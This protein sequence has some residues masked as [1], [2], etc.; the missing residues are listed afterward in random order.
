MVTLRFGRAKTEGVML[1]EMLSVVTASYG[2]TPCNYG[3]RVVA[4]L[5]DF[6][7]TV[8]PP[9]IVGL[10]GLVLL[11]AFAPLGIV[12]MILSGIYVVVFPI[13]NLVRQGSK[14]ATFGKSQ[15]KIALVKDETGAPIGILFAFLRSILFWFFN[16]ITA[17]IF[18]IVDYLFPAFNKKRQ[19]IVDKLLSSVVVD[20]VGAGF[21][22]G[23]PTTPSTPGVFREESASLPPPT[24]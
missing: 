16:A 9:A 1:E 12:L 6:L 5:I 14:G 10:L 22:T 7:L 2:G 19:R 17:G 24:I 15:Q 21:S 23:S 13:V 11:F 8:V 3:K 18:L 20:S 4:Y